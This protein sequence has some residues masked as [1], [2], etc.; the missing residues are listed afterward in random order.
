MRWTVV[1]SNSGNK[2]PIM[3]NS[4]FRKI[5]IIAVMLS[6]L[7]GVLILNSSQFNPDPSGDTEFIARAQQKSAPGI[8]VSASA[9]GR[10][11]S[12]RSFGEDLGKYDIQPIWLSIKNDTDDQLLLFSIAM[13]P[14]YYSPYEVSYKFHGA[15]SPVANRARDQFF[16]QRQMPNILAPHSLTTGF[17]YG[18]VDAGVKYARPNCHK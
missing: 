8:T 12:R 18:V 2:G 16:L 9:L 13:D 17:M 14:N 6:L 3:I 7:A 1:N 11:E 15:F 4:W 5:L 10:Q